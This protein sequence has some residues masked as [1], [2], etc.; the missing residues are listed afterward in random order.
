MGHEFVP[1]ANRTDAEDFLKDHK[2]KRIVSF[3]Q[4]TPELAARLD[5]G[6]FD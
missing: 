6:S 3:A 4:T 2:G 5:K 1:L